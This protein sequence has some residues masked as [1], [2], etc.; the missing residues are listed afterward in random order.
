M[1][2]Q[3]IIWTIIISSILTACAKKNPTPPNTNTRV[4][5]MTGSWLLTHIGEEIISSNSDDKQPNVTIDTNAKTITGYSGCNRMSGSIVL[6]SGISL[7][8]GPMAATKRMCA[9]S[10]RESQFLK[11]FNHITEY[12]TEGSL[13]WC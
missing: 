8:F 5:S 3:L 7:K 9:E 6:L 13:R 4:A 10:N 11:A 12:G 1:R 2:I